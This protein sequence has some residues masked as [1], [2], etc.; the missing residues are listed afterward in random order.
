MTWK[1]NIALEFIL[2]GVN[3][4]GGIVV[5]FIYIYKVKKQ[6]YHNLKRKPWVRGI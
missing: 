4:W 6:R 3:D 1:D 5:L 2:V